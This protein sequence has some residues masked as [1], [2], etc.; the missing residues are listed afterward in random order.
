MQGNR[1]D[2]VSISVNIVEC[3]KRGP[4]RATSTH[5]IY[6]SEL[7]RAYV[8]NPVGTP[9]T[10]G[11]SHKYTYLKESSSWQNNILV[12]RGLIAVEGYSVRR[13]QADIDV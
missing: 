2:L 7:P 4:P 6:N 11:V 13:L 12:V 5:R 10:A 1:G 3:R 9:R 8:F